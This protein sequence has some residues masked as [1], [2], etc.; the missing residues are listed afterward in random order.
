MPL[1]SAASQAGSIVSGIRTER[2]DVTRPDV[3][4]DG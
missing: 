1:S 4:L 3:E 2:G